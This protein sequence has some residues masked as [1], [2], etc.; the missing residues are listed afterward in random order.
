MNYPFIKLPPVG[1][2]ILYLFEGVRPRH[3]RERAEDALKAE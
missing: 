1:R 3:E 2:I